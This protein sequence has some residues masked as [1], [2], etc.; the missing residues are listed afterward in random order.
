MRFLGIL[1][2]V[3][4]VTAGAVALGDPDA[5]PVPRALRV[6]LTSVSDRVVFEVLGDGS[7]PSG[8]R[9]L[10]V[11]SRAVR[12]HGD[13]ECLSSSCTAE[14]W[15]VGGVDDDAVRAWYREHIEPLAPWR[16][17]ASCAA[18]FDLEGEDAHM[19][20]HYRWVGDETML[21]IQL[22]GESTILVREQPAG[23]LPCQ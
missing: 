16:G 23:D 3:F 10:P 8:I 14:V 6:P 18:V 7:K 15:S 13:Y 22:R 9:G 17:W 2:V 4:A 21:D 12:A 1:A 5:R 19:S 20:G 11:P